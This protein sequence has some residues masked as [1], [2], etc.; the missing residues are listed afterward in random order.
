MNKGKGKGRARAKK[1]ADQAPKEVKAPKKP[2]GN[3]VERKAGKAE[4]D[5]P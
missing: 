2:S 1:R 4:K 3:S 5:P